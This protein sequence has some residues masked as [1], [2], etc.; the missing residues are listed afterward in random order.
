MPEAYPTPAGGQRLTAT[1]LRAMQP[2]AA[3]KTADTQLTAT[4]TPTAD[5][6]ILFPVE[7]GAVY[8]WNGWIKYDGA[9]GGDILLTWTAPSGALGE[10]GGHGA[11]ITVIGAS[12]TPTLEID[13]VRTNGYM[14]RTESNDVAQ[15]RNFGCL[16][17]G[18]PLTV[19]IAGTLRVQGTAGIFQ[20]AWAQGTSNATA[21]T[22]Y[23]DSC[24]QLQRIA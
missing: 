4:T 9:T 22:L 24:V 6:H 5:P 1:L 15:S 12:S 3:R 2:Q 10:W 13:T 19:L 21:S 11:G 16:G 14:L 7:A 23:T 20:L 18:N 8:T 17:V